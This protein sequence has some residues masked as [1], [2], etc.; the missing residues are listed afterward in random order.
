MKKNILKLS[1]LLLAVVL[2]NNINAQEHGKWIT[3]PRV[4]ASARKKKAGSENVANWNVRGE[5]K[6]I[7][8]A[9]ER[10]KHFNLEYPRS[11]DYFNSVFAIGESTYSSKLS[12]E[13]E[14]KNISFMNFNCSIDEQKKIEVLFFDHNVLFNILNS[15]IDYCFYNVEVFQ[16]L[17]KIEDLLNSCHPIIIR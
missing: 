12:F 10:R 14:K 16:D 2:N 13:T 5:A 17:Q 8:E 6:L 7:D 1:L 9:I 11:L 15:Q 4:I 3:I